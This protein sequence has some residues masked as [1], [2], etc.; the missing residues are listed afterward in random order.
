MYNHF[1]EKNKEWC[2]INMKKRYIVIGLILIGLILFGFA[3]FIRGK[4]PKEVVEIIKNIVF[5]IGVGIGLSYTLR[6]ILTFTPVILSLKQND[7]TR[8]NY[9]LYPNDTK[10]KAITELSMVYILG[11]VLISF[12]VSIFILILWNVE[13][14]IFGIFISL[15]IIAAGGLIS[16]VRKVEQKRNERVLTVRLKDTSGEKIWYLYSRTED[17]G[18]IFTSNLQD[19]KNKYYLKKFDENKVDLTKL[20]YLKQEKLINNF[21]GYTDALQPV[22]ITQEILPDPVRDL[23]LAN[24]NEQL[25]KLLGEEIAGNMTDSLTSQFKNKSSHSNLKSMAKNIRRY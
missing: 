12:M 11:V 7:A 5:L 21:V 2:V 1:K 22:I 10:S 6:K 9:D 25:I 13:D 3:T 20:I 17:D 23:S 24:T 8:Y 15:Y 18:Y 14:I 16:R 4:E 19:I